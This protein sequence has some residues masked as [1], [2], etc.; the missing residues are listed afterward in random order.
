VV[1]KRRDQRTWLQVIGRGIYPKGGWTRA[2]SYV[3][4]RLRRLPDP[5][6]RIARGVAAG[7][8]VC[9]TPFFGLHFLLAAVLSFLMQ[10]NI[11]ASL[12][13]TFVGNPLTFPFIATI[14]LEM[15]S[16]MMGTPG[17][18]HFDQVARII[19]HASAEVWVNFRAIVTGDEYD[20]NRMG[21]FYRGVFRPYLVGG[22]VPGIL[23]GVG[24]YMLTVPAVAAYQNRRVKKLQARFEQRRA[25]LSKSPDSTDTDQLL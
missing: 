5:P 9:F 4:H 11:L 17:G 2:V 19:S 22:I 25:K 20:W 10:G 8:F 6:H 7:V 16:W 14:S 24:F 23:S 1:F 21:I 3:M 15:G 18:M 13:A 12:L